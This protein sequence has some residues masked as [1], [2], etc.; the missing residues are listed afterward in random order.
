MLYSI[1]PWLESHSLQSN[2][3]ATLNLIYCDKCVHADEEKW[4]ADVN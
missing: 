3:D 2:T 4:P 1:F